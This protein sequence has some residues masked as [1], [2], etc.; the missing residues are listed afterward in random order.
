MYAC[1]VTCKFFKRIVYLQAR[2]CMC[3]RKEILTFT[4]E[5]NSKEVSDQELRLEKLLYYIIQKDFDLLAVNEKR[6]KK[7][8]FLKN[9]FI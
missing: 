2:T 1:K 3:R 9:I 6:I 7:S 8:I 5:T 4:R